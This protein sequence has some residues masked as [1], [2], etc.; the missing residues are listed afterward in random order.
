MRRSAGAGII[1]DHYGKRGVMHSTGDYS[2]TTG[3]LLADDG[4]AAVKALRARSDITRVG[5]IGHSEGGELAAMIAA[6][7]PK[8]IDFL[9]SL[10]GPGL[11]GFD[12]MLLQDHVGYA[13]RGLSAADVDKLTKYSR[14]FYETVT[15]NADVDA[16]RTAL[17]ALLNKYSDADKVR[18]DENLDAI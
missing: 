10:A 2:A 5:V 13:R 6:E 16:R 12:L 18:V 7:H 17:M 1:E 9:V 11:K 8:L 4:L 3:A 15:A 14:L